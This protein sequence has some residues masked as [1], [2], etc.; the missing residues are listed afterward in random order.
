MDILTRREKE[1][2]QPTEQSMHI[3]HADACGNTFLVICADDMECASAHLHN[4]PTTTWSFDSALILLPSE[5]A[6][7]RMLVVEQDGSIST[8][9]GNGT[10]AVAA[11]LDEMDL[12]RTIEVG[13][14]VL[15]VHKIR[16]SRYAVNLGTPYVNG[17]IHVCGEPH[18]VFA[19]R[20]LDL[21]ILESHGRLCVPHANA[22]GYQNVSPNTII[23]RTFE[24]G[25]N[26]FT[27]SCGTG[28]SAAAWHASD[29]GTRPGSYSVQMGKF[30]LT[31]HIDPTSVTLEGDVTIR[32]ETS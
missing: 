11:V 22:T 32:K 13:H 5:T 23:A 31:A 17:A 4:L 2:L 3:Y 7:V 29:C 6:S 12:P 24:R 18:Q 10:R 15:E 21:N 19:M 20:E 25:V 28:A 16:P 9:C 1:S 30:V 14:G 27:H 8:M 26:R